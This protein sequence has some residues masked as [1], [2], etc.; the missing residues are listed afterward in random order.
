MKSKLKEM[1]EMQMLLEEMVNTIKQENQ[2]RNV[3]QNKFDLGSERLMKKQEEIQDL[4]EKIMDDELKKLLEEFEELVEETNKGKQLE[5]LDELDMNL[6]KLERQLDVS[7]ELLKRF[8]IE[9]E[10]FRTANELEKM[11]EEMENMDLNQ[12]STGIE[13]KKKEFDKLNENYQ[14]QIDKNQELSEPMK[15]E[16][17]EEEREELSEEMDEMNEMNQNN[18]S[19]NEMEKKKKS[20]QDKMSKLGQQMR[21]MMLG[22]SGEQD[23]VD[24]ELLR[25]LA[26]ELNDY[27]F[28]Q[29]DL[30]GIIQ[31]VNSA[32]PEY[33]KAGV[34]QRELK[35]KFSVIRD[36][37]V[38]LGYKQPSIAKLLNQEMFHVETALEN[39]MKSYQDGRKSQVSIEQQNIMT[40]A[41]ELAVRLDEII[42]S[43]QNQSGS[44]G[45]KSSFTD[46]KPKSGKDKIGD[47][48]GKQQSLKQ[49]LEGMIQQ[50]KNNKGGKP[51]NKSLA[52][53]LADREMLR[54]ALEKLQNSGELGEPAKGKLNEVQQLMEQVEKDIIYNRL[55]D[56]TIRREKMIET[57]LLEAEQAEMERELEEKREANEFKGTIKPPDEKIWKDFEQEKKKTLEL[58]RYRDIKLKEFYRKKYFDY[59]EQLEKRKN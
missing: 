57:K 20:A 31:R 30:I 41:N 45:G 51:D 39:L 56:N 59:L 58:M 53:M 17:F 14:E 50:M 48:K 38:S 10:V 33:E 13:E 1:E 6:E 34:E 43:A 22:A 49:Q 18:G 2:I 24:I 25:Q 46:S 15:L 28:K 27:S 42:Q 12:D 26:R 11:A 44:G 4:L 47:M 36:S 29:E 32:H 8:E 16:D 55:G 19:K 37:L 35:E 40:G 52:K 54:Q 3:E 9:K 7:L 23:M 21:E 5:K